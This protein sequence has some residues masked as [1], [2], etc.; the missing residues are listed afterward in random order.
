MMQNQAER[1]ISLAS[2]MYTNHKHGNRPQYHNTVS[3]IYLLLSSIETV[4]QQYAAI[5]TPSEG[6]WFL[7]VP[8]PIFAHSGS[9]PMVLF[10]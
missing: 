2:T 3:A 4:A 5:V 9:A 1:S 8:A 10:Y 7:N 6:N